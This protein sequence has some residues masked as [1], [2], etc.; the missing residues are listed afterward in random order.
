M[1]VIESDQWSESVR[2]AIIS[3]AV[4][5]ALPVS[6]Y[7][8]NANVSLREAISL[9][10]ERHH[11]IKAAGFERTAAASEESVKRS[12]YLPRILMEEG[13]AASNAPT[14]VF[15][16]KLDQG[17]FTANDFEIS[18]LN[19][20][21][22]SN[23]FS[24]KLALEQPLFDLS[25]GQG[26][27][28]VKNEE[29]KRDLLLEGRR[30]EVASKVYSAYL[31]IR[32]ARA[33]LTA[34]EQALIDAREHQ[35]LAVVRGEAGMGLKSDEL[36]ARTFLSEIEQQNIT[37]NNNLLLA[38]M[39]LSRATAGDAG[40]LLDISDGIDVLH[41]AMGIDDLKRL[42]RQNR[43][44]IQTMEKDVDKAALGVKMARSAY[45]PTIYADAS[46]QLNDRDVPFG[47]DND[48]WFVGATLRWELF[49]GMRRRNEVMKNV[50]LEKA[51]AEYVDDYKQDVDLQV[52]ESFLRY[53]EAQKKLEVARNSSADADESVRLL[54]KR[55]QNSLATM[56][57]LLDAQTAL[58]RA[59]AN[60][61]DTE[62][63]LA[64]SAADIYLAAGT[65]LQEVMK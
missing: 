65:F 63:Q 40:E 32:R 50:A 42:A 64:L 23:D 30:Q 45:L 3:I 27:E 22:A 37:A 57:E 47:N 46:Y 1:A 18:N 56:S 35:R 2:K 9:A 60:V 43:I 48:S 13:V 59:R 28:M 51:A 21:K 38:K 29:K 34:T 31:E 41:P 52:T 6:A 4:I 20:P 49:D 61:I 58:N 16:M 39:K 33:Y 14:R 55:F 25:I 15:M 11:L 17:R 24:T 26:V 44:D 53:Q 7:A 36:R 19:H 62:N 54:E 8:G 10:L 5:L 12:R